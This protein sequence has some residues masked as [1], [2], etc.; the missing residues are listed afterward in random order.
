MMGSTSLP[1]TTAIPAFFSFASM[2]PA[3]SARTGSGS[4]RSPGKRTGASATVFNAG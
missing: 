2:A 4:S 1:G 3:K